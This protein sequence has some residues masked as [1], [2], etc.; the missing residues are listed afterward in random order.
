MQQHHAKSAVQ[1]N[2]AAQRQRHAVIARQARQMTTLIHQQH[3]RL[4]L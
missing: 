1:V 2:T 4:A 3:A